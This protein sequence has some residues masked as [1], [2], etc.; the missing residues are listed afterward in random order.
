VITDGCPGMPVPDPR[1]YVVAGGTCAV[2]V[3]FRPTSLNPANK[4]ASL[5]VTPTGGVATVVNL[6]GT[7]VAVNVARSPGSLSFGSVPVGT[8]SAPQP[9]TVTNNGGAPVQLA[10]SFT[11]PSAGQFSQAGTCPVAPVALAGGASCVANVVLT[12]AGSGGS[13]TGSLIVTPIGN[14]ALPAVALSGTA[15]APNLALACPSGCGTAFSTYAFGSVNGAVSASFTLSDA[16]ATAA[17]F[18]I[19][20]ITVTRTNNGNGSYT[21][22]G[23]TCAVGNTLAVGATCTVVV[24][25]QSPAGFSNTSGRLTVSGTAAGGSAAYSVSRNLTGN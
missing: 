6:S 21:V 16:G 19:G 20:S 22:T 14:P 25:F 3:A 5:T 9:V 11:G 4:A 10:L 12:P 13:R 18:A 7:A 24:R 15:T 23:G 1:R 17:P 2:N 8:T